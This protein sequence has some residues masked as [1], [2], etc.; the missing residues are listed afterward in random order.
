MARAAR[1]A[2]VPRFVLVSSLAAGGPARA[3]RPRNEGD[4]DQPVGA[5]GASKRGGELR[6]A[7]ALGAD[8]NATD[9]DGISP[10]VSAI[11]NGHFDVA[12]RGI[13]PLPA[14]SPSGSA[15]S[16]RGTRRRRWRSPASV[17]RSVRYYVASGPR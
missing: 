15:W 8:V 2:G 7:E 13:L 4:A 9:Q 16:M 6:A 11:I 3:G 5:Y 1:R 10:L 17:P 12:D 14:G